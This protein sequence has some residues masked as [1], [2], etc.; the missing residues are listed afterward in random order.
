MPAAD[1]GRCETHGVGS[2]GSFCFET[3]DMKLIVVALTL[4]V[5]A[6]KPLSTPLAGGDPS[7]P[8]VPV[9]PVRY[10]SSLGAYGPQRP[11]NPAPWRQQNEQVAPKGKNP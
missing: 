11:V 10:Q 8:S 1:R 7:D 3:L 6:C 5:A 4:L 9:P 2:V